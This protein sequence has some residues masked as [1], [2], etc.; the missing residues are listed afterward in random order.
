MN[1]RRLSG[2]ILELADLQAEG[3]FDSEPFGCAGEMQLLGNRYE[4]VEM[5]ELHGPTTGVDRLGTLRRHRE[6][7]ALVSPHFTTV[8]S[9]WSGA[10]P[11]TR[12]ARFCC[13]FYLNDMSWV[14]SS[15]FDVSPLAKYRQRLAFGNTIG[16]CEILVKSMAQ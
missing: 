12:M 14:I 16:L 3:L 6:K 1:K 13:S 15:I 7:P 9:G 2:V 10:A 8:S 11:G 5:P 4:I